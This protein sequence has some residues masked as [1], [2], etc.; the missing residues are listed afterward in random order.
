LNLLGKRVD[1]ELSKVE[2]DGYSNHD[3]TFG[4]IDGIVCFEIVTLG[5]KLWEHIV[6]C[7]PK[8]RSWSKLNF[9][10]RSSL[11]SLAVHLER[12]GKEQTLRPFYNSPIN[13]GHIWGMLEEP[14]LAA[15]VKFSTILLGDKEAFPPAKM[16]VEMSLEDLI[17]VL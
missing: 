13:F 8:D 17:G 2:T 1:P 11:F 12:H 3:E 6:V 9:S 4:F 15:A 14:I 5:A 7:P 10:V 16:R